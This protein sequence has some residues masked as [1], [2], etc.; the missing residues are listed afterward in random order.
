MRELKVI[1]HS[2]LSLILV[3]VFLTSAGCMSAAS[4]A[5]PQESASQRTIT[6]S[7]GR[8]VT[9]P[10]EVTKTICASGGTCVRYLTYMNS[11][12]TL[13]AV[14]H[15]ERL[16]LTTGDSRAYVWANPG[17]ALIPSTGSSR[18]VSINLEQVITLN[19]EI[20]LTMGTITNQSADG[21]SSADTMQ[22]KTGIPVIT[23]A[24]GSFQ[25]ETSKTELYASW[26]LMGRILN[27]EDR[28]EKL[29]AYCDATIADLEKRTRDI[30][31]SQQRSAYIGGLSHGGA[32]GFM[33]T[34]SEYMPFIWNHVRNAAAGSGIQNADFS[35]EG[36]LYAD[37]DV[38]F[39]DAGTLGVTTGIGGFEEIKSPVYADM[40]AVKSGNV[41][42]TLPYTG[43]STNLETQ[44]VDA[45]YIG[46]I[47]YPDRFSDID[48]KVKA[49]EIYTMFVG[50][51]VF[52][53][54]NA[55]CDNLAFGRVP[56]K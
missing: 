3:A 56:L 43:R 42:A 37:P 26:R 24:S 6:D 16:N 2:A 33:S 8:M 45:Y 4:H 44:L 18:G 11:A 5:P 38:I 13:V 10:T 25:D 21:L 28:A 55:N 32:H 19:P 12:R 27:K 17:F 49:D 1:I 23:L 22:A 30:P 29:I 36:L 14:E 9:I 53:K 48:P 20:I 39:I 34:Q 47:M 40:K 51:P 35:K 52:E 7:S 31:E 50:V 54:L 15:G 46:K 41:Y